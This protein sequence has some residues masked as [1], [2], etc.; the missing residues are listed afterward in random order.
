MPPYTFAEPEILAFLVLPA[1][2]AIV[3]VWGTAA[4]CRRTGQ[5]S[6]ARRAAVRAVPGALICMGVTLGLADGGIF[7][8]GGTPLP[9]AGL[10]LAIVGLGFSIAF[11]PLGARLAQLPLWTL[12]A[13]QA[14][15]LPLEIAMHALAERGIMPEQMSYSGLNFD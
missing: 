15:R 11:S 2:M 12:V 8:H 5:A 9:F 1:I 13:A 7:L 3:F 10:V 6:S 14:F 4:A